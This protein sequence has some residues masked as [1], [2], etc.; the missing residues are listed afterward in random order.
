[1]STKVWIDKKGDTLRLRWNYEGKRVQISLGMRDDEVGRGLAKQKA[2][3]IEKEI[4][5]GCYDPTLLRYKPQK[6]GRN[7]T[8]ITAVELFEK[9][10]A[11]RHQ[12][13]G[14]SHSSKVRFKAIASKLSQFL[15]DRAASKVTDSVARDVVARWSE[16]VSTRT[17]KERLCDL[18]AC[19]DWAKGKYHIADTNPWAECLERVK[20]KGTNKPKRKEPFTIDELK[21]IVAAFAS[22][23]RHK[24]YHDFAFFLSGISCR[25]GEVVGLTW[26][27]LASDYS[28]A[29]I[30]QSIS[31]GHK[32]AKGTKTGDDRTVYL[33]PSVRAMLKA[34]F[35][36]LQPKPDDLVFCSPKGKAINDNN[37]CKRVWM[38]LLAS[39][40]IEYR[41]PYNLRHSASSHALRAGA[42]PI[43]LAKQNGHS[44]RTLLST[45]AH[46]I[47]RKCLFVDLE[48]KK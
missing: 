27:N 2:G 41:P 15:G 36:R 13:R 12:E 39:C 46:E 25:P 4:A 16:S 32:N 5:A 45:Y 20:S 31:R 29:W 6:L 10:A 1:M 42:D 18:C 48:T 40:G 34:R 17:I 30:C 11:H 21:T 24:H 3:Q 43:A 35:E 9:Y 19:W 14:L 26:E 7:P 28:S 23:P 22:H 47:D 37:F 38:P 33:P 44:V 8:Q